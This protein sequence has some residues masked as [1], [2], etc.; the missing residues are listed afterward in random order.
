MA[1]DS[2][3]TKYWIDQIIPPPDRIPSKDNLMGQVLMQS[4][5]RTGISMLTNMIDEL[6]KRIDKLESEREHFKTEVVKNTQV[7]IVD[8][9]S[10][11]AQ[12]IKKTIDNILKGE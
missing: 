12:D 8:S 10:P 2:S 3:Y 4:N 9:V 1:Y 5:Q 6:Y 7:K 11:V